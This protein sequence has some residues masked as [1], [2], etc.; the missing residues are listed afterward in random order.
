MAYGPVNVGQAQVENNNYLTTDQMGA[1]GGLATLDEEG[2]LAES[3]RPVIDTYTKSQTEEMIGD[4][5]D[6]H[7]SSNIA[8]QDIRNT[9]VTATVQVSY[10]EGVS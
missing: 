10:N 3:Q 9:M 7:A 4:A 1:A 6:A 2:K 8:H 5:V